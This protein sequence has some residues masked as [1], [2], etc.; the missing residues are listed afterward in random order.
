MDD[1]AGHMSDEQIFPAML[2]Q[3]WRCLKELQRSAADSWEPTQSP[4]Q[5]PEQRLVQRKES[6]Q[7]VRQT[8][9]LHPWPHCSTSTSSLENEDGHT[10]LT[11]NITTS[12]A[13][14]MGKL[15]LT[16]Q[17]SGPSMCRELAVTVLFRSHKHVKKETLLFHFIRKETKAQLGESTCPRL[18]NLSAEARIWENLRAD[19]SLTTTPFHYLSPVPY[20]RHSDAKTAF[21]LGHN[22]LGL[23]IAPWFYESLSVTKRQA[24]SSWRLQL[25]CTQ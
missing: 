19:P 13:G 16:G 12:L 18:H 15:I 8:S 20:S 7:G 9:P 24:H 3:W 1:L 22:F 21:M 17:H 5:P 6:G 11:E 4:H 23:Y 14:E 10:Y 2:L 25:Y